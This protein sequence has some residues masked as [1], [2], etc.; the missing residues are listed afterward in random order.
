MSVLTFCLVLKA[1]KTYSVH[2]LHTV[3]VGVR[4]EHIIYYYTLRDFGICVSVCV[5]WFALSPAQ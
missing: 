4:H 3:N 5:Y 2:Q 1:L